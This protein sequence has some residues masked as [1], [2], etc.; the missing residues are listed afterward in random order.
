MK[1]ESVTLQSQEEVHQEDP[2][3]PA[4]FGRGMHQFLVNV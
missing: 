2:L 3:G 1:S 4:L